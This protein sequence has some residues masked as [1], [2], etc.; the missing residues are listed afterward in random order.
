MTGQIRCH[1]E[2]LGIERDA[3][4]ATIKKAHRKLALKHHPDKNV[5]KDEQQQQESAAEF[6]LVGSK[7][8][9]RNAS[10]P[11]SVKLFWPK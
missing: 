6:K 7:I 5:G 8:A 11:I 4:A 3:D 1:Y 10:R 9:L 2:V